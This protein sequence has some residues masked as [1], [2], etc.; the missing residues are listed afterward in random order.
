[1][2]PATACGKSTGA[3]IRALEPFVSRSQSKQAVAAFADRRRDVENPPANIS[4]AAANPPFQFPAPALEL[5]FFGLDWRIPL[6]F[7]WKRAEWAAA[8][9]WRQALKAVG[10]FAS[11]ADKAD[12][13]NRFGA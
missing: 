6:P 1:M 13:I 12:Y 2:S 10:T 11:T 5:L 3:F 7:P 9:F 4:R 8:G